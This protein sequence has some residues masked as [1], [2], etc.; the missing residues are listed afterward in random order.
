MLLQIVAV[1]AATGAVAAGCCGWLLLLAAAAAAAPARSSS[2]LVATVV[3]MR[4]EAMRLVSRGA[5]LQPGRHSNMQQGAGVRGQAALRK[6]AVSLALFARQ[7]NKQLILIL[8]MSSSVCIGA[9][10]WQ[11]L[12]QPVQVVTSSDEVQLRCNSCPMRLLLLPAQQLAVRGL[13]A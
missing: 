7:S 3:P 10:A 9:C 1:A 2:A 8:V 11:R 12:L 4:M 5:C 6:G 13:A